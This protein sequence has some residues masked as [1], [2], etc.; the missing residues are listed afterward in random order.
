[1]IYFS[2]EIMIYIT[3]R[4]DS[5]NNKRMVE[6]TVEAVLHNQGG[7]AKCPWSRGLINGNCLTII[8]HIYIEVTV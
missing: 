6:R 2:N 3:C 5:E 4:L 8:M 7:E 1:M